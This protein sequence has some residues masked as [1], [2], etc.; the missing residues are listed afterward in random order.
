MPR[1]L[2]ILAS[3]VLLAGTAAA[4]PSVAPP[5]GTPVR[6]PKPRYPST[7]RY[8]SLGATLGPV[9]A[10]AAMLGFGSD[11]TQYGGVVIM[12][13]GG[14]VGPAM[15]LWYAGHGGGVGL[16]ARGASAAVFLGGLFFYVIIRADDDCDPDGPPCEIPLPGE[17]GERRKALAVA[18]IGAAG[19][20]ASF[21]YDTREAGRIVER[22]NRAHRLTV[23]PAMLTTTT[24][25]APGAV[26]SFRF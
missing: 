6:E 14:V 20:L 13:T 22:N 2:T 12:A 19:M 24:G 16:L 5:S 25:R 18:A 15:G 23:T 7:A 8:W 17:A 3:L 1:I 10:G 26:L 11:G 21:I 9:A 4:Q